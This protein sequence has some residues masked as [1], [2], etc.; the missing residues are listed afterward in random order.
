MNINYINIFKRL[1]WQK[2]PPYLIFYVTS[3]CNARCK[4]CFFYENLNKIDELSIDEIEKFTKNYGPLVQCTLTGGEPFLRADFESII[5]LFYKNCSPQYFTIPTNGSLPERIIRIVDNCSKK[6]DKS[7]FRISLSIDNIGAKH[8]EIRN[9][10]GLF[11]KASET[12]YSLKKLKQKN[13]SVDILTVL[14][15]YNENDL[16][17]IIDFVKKKFNPDNHFFLYARGNPADKESLNFELESFEKIHREEINK[18]YKK[19]N[20]PFSFIFRNIAKL[21]QEIIL[22]IKKKKKC[23]IECKAGKKMLVVY[24]NGDIYPCELLKKKLDNVKNLEYNINKLFSTD[25]Y[26]TVIQNIKRG[27]CYCTWECAIGASV[28]YSFKYWFR[29]LYYILK[30]H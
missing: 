21:N 8:D 11:E 12:Y 27:K 16:G 4:F 2:V 29:L 22:E 30:K 6:F 19:E 3:K 28:F 17:Y 9:F 23:V 20:R 15:K 13:I 18:L 24:S 5:E 1:F 25:T 26:H 7:F 14:N 10:P